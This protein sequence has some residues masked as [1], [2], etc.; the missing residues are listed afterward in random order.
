[1]IWA[2][3][4]QNLFY[5][6]RSLLNYVPYVSSGLRCLVPHMFPWPAYIVPYVLSSSL[7]TS[8]PTCSCSLLASCPMCSC[9]LRASC[10]T[11]S[12]ASR[13]LCPMCFRAH[14][15]VVF[16]VSRASRTSYPTCSCVSRASCFICLVP[17]ALWALFSYVLYCF[18]RCILIAYLCS[19]ITCFALEFPCIKLLFFC[20]FATCDFFGGNLLKLKQK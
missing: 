17:C 10:P 3:F 19:N 1:M 11:C 8:C 15:A 6:Q 13:V 2:V 4:R 9:A 5:R 12:R 18:V 7:C 20:S 14:R 16:Y